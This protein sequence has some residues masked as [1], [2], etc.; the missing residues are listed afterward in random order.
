MY[1]NPTTYDAY[2]LFHEG[3]LVLSQMEAN[4]ILID[5]KYLHTTMNDLQVRISCM[6]EDLKQ[7][8]IY[9]TWKR[10]YG[11]NTN[12]ASDQQ[13]GDILFNV[14]G[15]PCTSRTPKT[16]RPQVNISILETLNSEFVNNLL[17]IEKL[18]TARNTFLKG[19]QREVASDGF[20]HPVFN[21]HLNV[22]YRGSSDSPNFQNNPKR[23]DEQSELV[24]R[25]FIPRDK[26]RQIVEVDFKGSEVCGAACYHHDPVMIKYIK[27]NPGRI[28]TDAARQCYLLS[29]Q[30]MTDD[31]RYCGKNKFVFPQ[32]YG[33]WYIDCAVALWQA[34]TLMHLKT[35]DGIKLKKHL[36]RMGIKELGAC[37]P[38]LKP[39][40]G[41]FEA[42]IKSV[43]H[44]FWT[45]F[46]IYKQWKLDW[47][48]DYLEQGYFDLLSGFRVAGYMSRNQVI[49]IPIQGTSFH[50]LLWCLIRVNKLLKKYKMKTLVYL[51]GQ[52]HDSIFGDVHKKELKNYVDIVTQVVTEDILK[53][54]KWIIV[55][56]TVE[57]EA[58][59]PGK[60]WY[61]KRKIDI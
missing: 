12:L 27:T 47:Y 2:Q 56:L 40:P 38:K 33:D 18:K 58:A 11:L 7:H 53:H 25:C 59:P 46:K 50:F 41:T 19:I 28:H 21:L 54:W 23:D 17:R 1:I 34:M 16:G 15:Y 61:D 39:R 42:H 9:R 26:D 44:D 55:P 52:I 35:A 30:Q 60:S 14:L 4:G 51:A 37:N 43:E 6:Y 36:R 48:D 31:I 45:K 24:R 10:K 49:N 8:K 3:S 20:L 5:T 32:F 13:L 57:V 29:K 22:S